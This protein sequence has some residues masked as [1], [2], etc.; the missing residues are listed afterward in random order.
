MA[1]TAQWGRTGALACVLLWSVAAVAQ[2]QQPP[3]PADTPANP[4]APQASNPA[5]RP[6]F[7]DAFGRWLGDS[8]A[9]LDLQ[10]KG[11]QEKLDG[12]RSQADDAAKQAAGTA[13]K[14]AAGAAQQ[15]AGAL[16]GLPAA[17]MVN[18]R[19][20]CAS[21][22]NGA[23]DCEPAADTLCRDKGFTSGRGLEINTAQKCPA[24]VW[25]S[26]RMPVAGECSVETFVTR[27]VC[28]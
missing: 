8:K 19:S 9:A 1:M 3:Q 28:Q 26:G 10:L 21:A 11:T 17:R 4:P 15:A 27:A 7:I 18:G 6:G 14:Q 13:A 24:W 25:F 22:P 23:P 5:F 20:R 16:A 2:D 12:L